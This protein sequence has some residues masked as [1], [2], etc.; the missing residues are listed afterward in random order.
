[1]WV[2]INDINIAE[3]YSQ[4]CRVSH[5]QR[6]WWLLNY[7]KVRDNITNKSS[8]FLNNCIGTLARS[9]NC[10]LSRRI[11]AEEFCF[12]TFS[13]MRAS[14]YFFFVHY[15]TDW[16]LWTFRLLSI[17]EIFSLNVNNNYEHF[18]SE[19]SKVFYYLTL[20]FIYD[21]ISKN[22]MNIYTSFGAN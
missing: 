21:N 6:P 13:C 5:L 9:P 19:F 8:L 17:L 20:I 10:E 1:M 11:H 15:C 12:N 3:K 16:R 14:T 4:C 22:L 2:Y 18:K 7:T